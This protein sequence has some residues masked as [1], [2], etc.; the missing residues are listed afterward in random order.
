MPIEIFETVGW[1][2]CCVIIY[3]LKYG[4]I[5]QTHG[6]GDLAIC[7][8]LYIT[9]LW[10]LAQHSPLRHTWVYCIRVNVFGQM[11]IVLLTS[12]STFLDSKLQT[13]DRTITTHLL[14][15]ML[16]VYLI[17]MIMVKRLSI[18]LLFLRMHFY[19]LVLVKSEWK[20][21]KPYLSNLPTCSWCYGW[22][23]SQNNGQLRSS[24]W[25]DYNRKTFDHRS[26]RC[27]SV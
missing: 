5:Q 16:D 27:R 6:R 11:I 3:K 23:N 8:S 20:R 12:L 17:P 21:E 13:P 25:N 10:I 24:G 4:L 26:S 14:L 9:W 7:S 18:F 15:N 22:G 2:C 1:F 19:F